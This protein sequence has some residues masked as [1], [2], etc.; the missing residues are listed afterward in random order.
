MKTSVD[1]IEL[2][3]S[4]HPRKKILI[5]TM[6]LCYAHDR[7][8]PHNP[9]ASLIMK[10]A[11]N[12]NIDAHLA[13]QNLAEFYSVVTG[14]RVERPIAPAQAAKLSRL[15]EE[16]V[17]IK[18]LLPTE[19]AYREALN[20]AEDRQVKGGDIFDCILAYT[21]RGTVDTIWTDNTKHFTA[22]SFLKAENPLKWEWKETEDQ[23]EEPMKSR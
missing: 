5:D 15:Y 23:K 14:K 9:V 12:G 10:A 19:E 20:T 18:V 17:D 6:I 2:P 16:C 21:A 7:L 3:E 4:T 11:I 8:S 13:Y 1:G 22:Y